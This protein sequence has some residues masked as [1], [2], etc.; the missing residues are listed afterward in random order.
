MA[1]KSINLD[2][3]NLCPKVA[4][5]MG[6][7]EGASSLESISL[8]GCKLAEQGARAILTSPLSLKRLSLRDNG[9]SVRSVEALIES[10]L[11]GRLE[12]LK[13]CNKPLKGG[14]AHLLA[15]NLPADN[16]SQRVSSL[17]GWH[18]RSRQAYLQIPSPS[19][20][21]RAYAGVVGLVGIGLVGLAETID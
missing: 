14:G 9:L 3:S 13:M 8:N 10:G 11:L 21:R 16:N 19:P 5:L 1:L 17:W 12:V 6:Q 18:A 2:K 15:E 20:E 7:W 4:A